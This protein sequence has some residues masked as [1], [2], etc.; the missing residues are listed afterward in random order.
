MATLVENES[1][2]LFIVFALFAAVFVALVLPLGLVLGRV[3]KKLEVK[4]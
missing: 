4:R 3:A 1:S 2:S